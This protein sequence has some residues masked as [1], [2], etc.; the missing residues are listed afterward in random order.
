[1]RIIISTVQ[2]PF[3]TGGAEFL[4]QNLKSAFIENGHEAEIVTI[5]FM[6]SPLER[7]ED[8][9]VASRLLELTYGWA[10][11]SDLC[12]GLKFPAYFIPHENK[13]LWILHQHRN[14]YDLF[15]APSSTIK[16]DE[17]GRKFRD[18]VYR[19][20]NTYLPEAKRL[21]TIADNVAGRLK[22][23]NGL[24]AQTLYHPC[25]DH[26]KFYAEEYGDYILMP[27]RINV[28]K[29]QMLALEAMEH[30]KSDIKLYLVGQAGT[31]HERRQLLET[32]RQKGLEDKV[33]YFD[34]VSTGRKLEL[35]ANARAVLFIPIDEDYG[36]ITLE[37][38]EAARA[39]ITAKDSG[40]PLEFVENEKN[41]LIVSPEPLEIAKAIDEFAHSK[42]MARQMGIAAKT[43]LSD[44]NITWE[45]VVKELT[46]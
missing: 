33:R 15:N 19:A 7:L 17:T 46:K 43:R 8:H 14:A 12:I 6:D 39:V 21:Y 30:V 25:P 18:I 20:D 36:Y 31:E 1:M 16:D 41:G 35:Y 27:S 40:G 38:M 44:M 28:T 24:N 9:I 11:K 42:K 26:D 3:I 23:Y 22:R 13:V 10:G 45:N 5:P 4:A 2:I 29:R 34:F 37:A 32:I